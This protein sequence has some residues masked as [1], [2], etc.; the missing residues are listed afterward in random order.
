MAL[1][2]SKRRQLYFQLR[3]IT[4]LSD[5][6]SFHNR[7]RERKNSVTFLYGIAYHKTRSKLL[8][9]VCVIFTTS[10]IF[11]PPPFSAPVCWPIRKKQNAWSLSNSRETL[12]KNIPKLSVSL[13]GATDWQISQQLI[14]NSQ[15]CFNFFFLFNLVLLNLTAEVI[16]CSM[17]LLQHSFLFPQVWMSHSCTFVFDSA[18]TSGSSTQLSTPI[19]HQTCF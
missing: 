11:L 2:N 12:S 5:L 3:W 19:W 4:P 7:K 18:M 1:S 15:L 6:F 10:A 9:L 13:I 16:S 8:L 14:L 17:F